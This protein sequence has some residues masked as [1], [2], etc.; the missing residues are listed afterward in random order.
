MKGK[1]WFRINPVNIYTEMK[2]I[3]ELFKILQDYCK[4]EEKKFQ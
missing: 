4:D 1:T 3:D 2:H